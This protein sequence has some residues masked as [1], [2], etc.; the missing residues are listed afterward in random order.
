MHSYRTV[1]RAH[2]ATTTRSLVAFLLI[3]SFGI[4]FVGCARE[5]LP[6]EE[7]AEEF[8][9]TERDIERF[10]ELARR[11]TGALGVP[12]LELSGDEEAV[13]EGPPILDLARAETYRAIR[14]AP[15]HGGEEVFRVTNEFVNV[16]A[17]PSVTADVTDRL[18]RGA[19]L[20]VLEFPYAA[21]AH[22]RYGVKR[23]G[24]VSQRYIAKIVAEQSLAQE[25]E[26]FANMYFV[27]F[28][29]LN[30]R[31]E[32]DADSEKIGELPGQT[33]VRPLSVDEVWAKIAFEGREGYVAVQYL[34]PFLPN[35]LVRQ[36]AYTLPILH[37]SLEQEGMTDTIVA[38]ADRL[39]KDGFTLTTLAEL[40]SVLLTQE[41]R[42]VR[43]S[44]NRVAIAVSGVT[45]DSLRGVSDTLRARSVPATLFIQT[46]D[47]GKDGITEKQ[48]LTLD[49]NGFDV[50][51]AAHTGDDL[52]SLTNAQVDLELG[53][54]R[55]LLEQLTGKTVSAVLYPRGGVNERVAAKAGDAGYLLGVGRSHG[56]MFTRGELLELSSFTMKN[57][58]T[59]EEAL[60]M[61]RGGEGT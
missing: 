15:G 8:A 36:D 55:Q 26:K 2:R 22:V 28:G 53:Q 42:D 19:A 50:Q 4:L 20:E 5:E 13:P 54:S 33:I 23:E 51:S 41:E 7:E 46:S 10:R 49:A 35:F 31:K 44:P 1:R 16:R 9:F 60:E 47:V 57:S 24:H 59:A 18:E 40:M 56:R 12:H 30:V 52:R 48:M 38:H 29:F 6:A 27:D 61:V 37:Y 34:S 11:G 58:T 25:K 39:R 32:R 21:W 14:T 3:A 43:L 45:A 17:E